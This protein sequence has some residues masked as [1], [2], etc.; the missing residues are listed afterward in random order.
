MYI[1]EKGKPMTRRN[2]L[3]RKGRGFIA[4]DLWKIRVSEMG[5]VKALALRFLRIV[6]LSVRGFQDDKLPLRASGLTFYSL[7]SLVPV[8]ALAFGIAKGFGFQKILENRLLENFQGQEELL[9]RMIGYAN[10]LLETTK[11]GLMAGIG[12]AV[13][14]WTAIK[15]LS[16]IEHSFNDIWGVQ[17]PR[18]FGRKFSD[19]L[20]VMLI[21]PLLLIMSGSI[22]VFIVSGFSA[23]MEKIPL[24]GMISAVIYPLLKLIPYGL[25]WILFTVIYI[26]MP[27]T[28]VAIRSGLVAGIVS[29]TLYHGLQWIYIHFQVGASRYN[30]IYGSFAALPLFLVWLQM[31]WLIVLLGA[32]ISFAHQNTDEYEYD[33]DTQNISFRQKR[34]LCL[35]IVQR[36]VK[37]FMNGDAPLTTLRISREIGAPLRLVRKLMEELVEAGILSSTRSP[38]NGDPGYQP[39]RDIHQ[40]TLHSVFEALDSLGDND[41]IP[42]GTPEAIP[43]AKALAS[44]EAEIRRS[45]QNKLIKDI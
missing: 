15:V 26:L 29:G 39:A 17:S 37:N 25:L 44:L 18:S 23:V 13:L 12:I 30:A 36:A 24:P 27:N 7:L 14:F 2:E 34:L 31:S 21:G 5:R 45:P 28:K 20:S 11:G 22:S 42:E 38:D 8:L 10:S 1:D 35:M 19:Y 40:L 4:D 6:I 9:L 33:R 41:I 32:E 3:I 43:F 16:H